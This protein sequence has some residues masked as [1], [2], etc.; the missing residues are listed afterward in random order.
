[1]RM[2][3]MPGS[4]DTAEAGCAAMT[5]SIVYPASSTVAVPTVGSSLF[6]C[7]FEP[8]AFIMT[9]KMLLGPTRR[10]ETVARGGCGQS[11]EEPTRPVAA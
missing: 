4:M 8:A 2:R 10:A 7:V 6:M 1:M 9:R 11:S 5:G 3:S